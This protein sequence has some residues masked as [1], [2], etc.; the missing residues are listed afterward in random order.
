MYLEIDVKSQATYLFLVFS[1]H[2]N[3]QILYLECSLDNKYLLF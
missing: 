1:K 3:H 2:F